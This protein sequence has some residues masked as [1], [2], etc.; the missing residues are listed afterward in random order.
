MYLRQATSTTVMLGPFVSSDGVGLVSLTISPQLIRLSKNGTAFVAKNLVASNAIHGENAW[1]ST[2]FN[3][4]DTGSIGRLQVACSISTALALWQE[5]TVLPSSIFDAW[6]AGTPLQ[7]V[8]LANTVITSAAWAA[9]GL[10]AASNLLATDMSSITG[11]IAA[12]S[13]VNALR[14]LRNRV[15][16]SGQLTVYAEDDTTAVWTGALTSHSSASLIVESN[17]A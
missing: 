9:S 13:P 16:T 2:I 8:G 12:R 14:I 3:D 5:Y 11:T 1:Y 10:Q 6:A 7:Y 4:T 17:P 15:T